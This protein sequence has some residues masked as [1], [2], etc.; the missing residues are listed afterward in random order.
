MRPGQTGD[1]RAPLLSH[2]I[3]SGDLS[4]VQIFPDTVLSLVE[5]I[6]LLHQLSYAIK[7]QF[8]EPKVFRCVF[9]A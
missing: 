2:L 4:L 9:N 8:N 1:L 5:I 3:Q 7:T 6:I